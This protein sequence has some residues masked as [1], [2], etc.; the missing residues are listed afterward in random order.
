MAGKKS[1]KMR[2]SHNHGK[3]TGVSNG[4]GSGNRGGFGR[5]GT[6]KKGDSKKP[7]FWKNAKYF[8]KFGFGMHAKN[9]PVIINIGDI[10]ERINQLILDKHVKSGAEV[11]LNLTELGFEKLLGAGSLSHAV[12]ITIKTA[13]EQAV[14]KVEAAG[15]KILN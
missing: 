11:S 13:S 3:G 1:H 6:G 7:A 14:K 5:A 9:K 4:R 2:G 12:T 15:G 10:E 8:G